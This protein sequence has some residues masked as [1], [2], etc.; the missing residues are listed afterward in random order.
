MTDSISNHLLDR[1]QQFSAKN[2]L[3]VRMALL[4]TLIAGNYVPAVAQTPQPQFPARSITGQL[5]LGGRTAPAGVQV[6]LRIV[7]NGNEKDE[8]GESAEAKTDSNGRFTFSHLENLGQNHGQNLF[9]ISATQSG[10]EGEVKVVDLTE[11]T[12]GEV[13][14]DLRP[15]QASSITEHSSAARS[16][17]ADGVSGQPSA[18][19]QAQQAFRSGQELLFQKHDP[20]AS[21]MELKKAVKLDPWNE[22][23]YMLLGL[24]QMQLQHWDEAQYAFHE[25]TKIQPG[26]AQAFLGVGS[27]LNEQ[28]QYAEAQK[29][30]EHSLELKPDS[31]EAHYELARSLAALGRWDDA[32]PHVQRALELN[33]DYAGPHALMGDIYVRQQDAPSA[34]AQFKDY[35]RLAPNGSLAPQVK[36]MVNELEAAMGPE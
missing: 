26:N 1:E 28:R 13:N 23:G 6:H 3:V 7:L 12:H 4:A 24:A 19:V 20:N 9:S 29:A 35:L 33:P 8:N 36:K 14:L 16:G 5:K 18:K 2:K 10:F 11:D 27:A 15:A 30:L 32:A 17:P 34:L 31:A 25:A 22:Q 21:I